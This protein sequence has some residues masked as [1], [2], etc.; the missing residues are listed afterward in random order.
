[1]MVRNVKTFAS[2]P[3]PHNFSLLWFLAS[4]VADLLIT[5]SLVIGLTSIMFYFPR[6]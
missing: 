6:V 1:V 5:I 3:K 4:C 2:K